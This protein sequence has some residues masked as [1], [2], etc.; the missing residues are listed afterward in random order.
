MKTPLAS[1]VHGHVKWFNVKNGYGFI[2]RDDN[3]EDV[4]IHWTSIIRNNP[5]KV[6]PSVGDGE[7]VEFDVVHVPGRTPEAVNVTGPSGAAVIGSNHAQ[8]II[9]CLCE[10]C[11]TENSISSDSDH[12]TNRECDIESIDNQHDTYDS[13]FDSDA[14]VTDSSSVCSDSSVDVWTQTK[15]EPSNAHLPPSSSDLA[16]APVSVRPYLGPKPHSDQRL[17]ELKEKFLQRAQELKQ[18]L[19][20]SLPPDE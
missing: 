12:R 10:E 15:S 6:Q 9:C 7:A 8:N 3:H 5:H 19:Y 14:A 18:K 17:L 16:P 11:M 13:D 20:S 1:K 4:F 2:T